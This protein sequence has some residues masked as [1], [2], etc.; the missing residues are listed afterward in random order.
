MLCTRRESIATSGLDYTAF[1]VTAHISADTASYNTVYIA[2]TDTETYSTLTGG[3]SVTAT[4]S[5][6][7]TRDSR[8]IL[9][10]SK[11]PIQSPDNEIV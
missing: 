3:R 1:P 10:C 2:A 4:T 8:V 11:E 5:K 6:A 7:P 9:A